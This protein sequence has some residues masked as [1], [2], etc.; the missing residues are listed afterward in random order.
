ME[1]REIRKRM[2]P[3]EYDFD[4]MTRAANPAAYAA[5][6]TD[7]EL[8][9]LNIHAEGVMRRHTTPGGIPAIIAVVCVI[10][11]AKRFFKPPTQP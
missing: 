8:R 2:N 5:N 6:L 7:Q 11:A 4:E 10:E 9:I 3:G 1:R